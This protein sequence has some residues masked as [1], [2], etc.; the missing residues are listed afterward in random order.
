MTIPEK[1]IQMAPFIATF[2]IILIVILFFLTFSRNKKQQVVMK[3]KKEQEKEKERLKELKAV[4][5]EELEKERRMEKEEKNLLKPLGK[6][7]EELKR[8]FFSWH[9]SDEQ[10]AHIERLLKKAMH[11][12]RATA[13]EHYRD[14]YAE[15]HGLPDSKKRKIHKEV[16]EVYNRIT[17]Q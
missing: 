4:I 6:S 12:S 13:N 16:M 7:G 11:A 2:L 14:I 8:R 3:I 1:I 5:I 10:I 9:R 17:A 15:Y